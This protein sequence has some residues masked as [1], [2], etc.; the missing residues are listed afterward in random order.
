MFCGF[1]SLYMNL[2][3]W[4]WVGDIFNLSVWV[5][6]KKWARQKKIQEEK[7]V[8]GQIFW[9][10][11]IIPFF[12]LFLDLKRLWDVSVC[13]KWIER[14]MPFMIIKI[15]YFLCLVAHGVYFLVSRKKYKGTQIWDFWV[16]FDEQSWNKIIFIV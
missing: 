13:S 14:G 4:L 1:K 6:E 9:C 2:C 8:K 7:N 3:F 5:V 12:A 11:M 16:L 15:F 10:L